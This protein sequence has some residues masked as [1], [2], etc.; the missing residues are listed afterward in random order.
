LSHSPSPEE[1]KQSFNSA[2]A[3]VSSKLTV[4]AHRLGKLIEKEVVL[5]SKIAIR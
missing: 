3:E 4:L 5:K 1:V 2:V